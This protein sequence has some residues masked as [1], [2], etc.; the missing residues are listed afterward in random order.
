MSRVLTNQGLSFK[1]YGNQRIEINGNKTFVTDQFTFEILILFKEY[2]VTGWQI[3]G[4]QGSY[5]VRGW[6]FYFDPYGTHRLGFMIFYNGGS[7][8]VW[9]PAGYPYYSWYRFIVTITKEPD[10]TYTLRMYINGSL[11]NTVTGLPYNP[12][13][14]TNPIV[15]GY[16]VNGLIG[17]FRF[18]NR[19]L[20]ANEVSD[21]QNGAIIKNGLICYLPLSEYEGSTA[22]DISG[23]GNN[24]T[25]YGAEW[26]IKKHKR[27]LNPVRVISV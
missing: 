2:Q 19:P 9:S 5:N 26:V 1:Q 14:E 11:V 12:V 4:Y 24:G 7:N 20:G 21:I 23:Y 22:K 27:L 18:Y 17:E 8:V 15:L 10:G 16:Q 13:I 3:C 6:R 25:I